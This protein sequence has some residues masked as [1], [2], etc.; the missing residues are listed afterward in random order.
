MSPD[1]DWATL[2]DD[3]GNT[4]EPAAFPLGATVKGAVAGAEPIAPGDSITD[5]LVFAI[6]AKPAKELLLTLPGRNVG[7]PKTLGF[8][9]PAPPQD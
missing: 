6:P 7:S 5:I 8:R 4:C 3:I 9:I 1:Q 2:K